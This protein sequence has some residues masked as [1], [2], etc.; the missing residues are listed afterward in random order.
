[1]NKK[2][3]L[4]IISRG[5]SPDTISGRETVIYNLWKI[6]KQ[7]YEVNLI[8]GWKN[9][10]TLLPK[11]SYKIDI[12]TKNKAIN[13]LKFYWDCRKY[14]KNINPD[15]ILANTLEIPKMNIP[16]VMIVY[17]FNFG[18]AVG[19]ENNSIIKRSLIYRKLKSVDKV[20]AIS[21]ATKKNILKLGISNKKVNTIHVGVDTNKFVPKY[22]SNTKFTITYPS[23]ILSG[24]GQHLAIEAIKLIAPELRKKLRLI[25]AGYI[26]DYKYYK[27]IKELA[28]GLP[29]DFETNVTDL[30]P[31]YQKADIVIFPTI[32]EEGFGYTAVEAMSCE[33]PVIYTDFPAIIE[34]TGNIGIN[35]KRGVA[36]KLAEGITKLYKDKKLRLKMGKEGRNYV[37]N[38]YRWDKVFRNYQKVY[39]ELLVNEKNG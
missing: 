6:A 29:V 36:S 19:F 13:Y 1:M 15:L 11:D 3:K 30:V 18:K 7:H 31:Y 12:S 16:T 34:S 22:P 21:S 14:L 2:I 37:L 10:P 8:S 24:K 39:N 33:K 26:S 5:F 27:K 32:M 38:H 4:A 23:R 17:D 25:I 20:I 35:F 28:E 9:N